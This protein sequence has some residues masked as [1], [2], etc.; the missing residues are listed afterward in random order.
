MLQNESSFGWCYH[1]HLV[2]LWRTWSFRGTQWKRPG[3]HQSVLPRYDI[4]MQFKGLSPCFSFLIRDY[5]LQIFIFEFIL[6]FFLLPVSYGSLPPL[7]PTPL[8]ACIL[9]LFLEHSSS[10]RPSHLSVTFLLAFTL[11]TRSCYTY[12]CRALALCMSSPGHPIADP[13]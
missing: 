6:A 3:R 10:L 4:V 9:F 2:L 8:S 5:S 11:S 1:L 13:L 12:H 7:H